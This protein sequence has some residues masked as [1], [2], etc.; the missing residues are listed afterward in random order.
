MQLKGIKLALVDDV[1]KGQEELT[2]KFLGEL[3]KKSKIKADIQLLK[4]NIQSLMAEADSVYKKGLD[5]EEKVKQLGIELPQDVKS[6]MQILKNQT[7][8]GAK[9]VKEFDSI[10]NILG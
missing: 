10:K 5:A 6:A 2:K 4:N 7:V 1:K 8:E 3:D 9:L